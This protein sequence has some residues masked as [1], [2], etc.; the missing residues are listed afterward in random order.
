MN[1]ATGSLALTRIVPML[2]VASMPKSVTFYEQLGFEVEHRNDEWGWAMLRSGDC[3]LMVDQSIAPHPGAPRT[4]IVYLYPADVAEYHAR[5]R[6]AGVA[7]PDLATTF[8]GMTEF[9]LDDPDGNHLW[10]GQPKP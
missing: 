9:R 4:G 8:Y 1:P 6:A 3:R 10:V 7:V 2:P 5:V